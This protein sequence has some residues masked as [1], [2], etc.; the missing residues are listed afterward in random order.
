MASRKLALVG[1]ALAGCAE[2]TPPVPPL[3]STTL[4]GT[5]ALASVNGRSVPYADQVGPILT[6]VQGGS[7][8]I[9]TDSTFRLTLINLHEIFCITS[10]TEGDF[11]TRNDSLHLTAR[12]S[13]SAQQSCGTTPTVTTASVPANTPWPVT[14]DSIRLR[15]NRDGVVYEFTRQPPGSRRI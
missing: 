1:V 12:R 10:V 9:L 13:G 4:V 2:P 8:Q 7:L 6:G 3:V 14:F 15:M 11:A 5:H